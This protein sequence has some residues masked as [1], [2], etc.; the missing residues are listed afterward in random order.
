MHLAPE[1]SVSTVVQAIVN[2]ELRRSMG[3]FISAG[4][5]CHGSHLFWWAIVIVMVSESL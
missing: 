5:D 3:A 2:V 1:V 4:I